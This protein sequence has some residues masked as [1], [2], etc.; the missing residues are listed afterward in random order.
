VVR[1][2]GFGPHHGHA[3]YQQIAARLPSPPED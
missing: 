3:V 1:V 2:R